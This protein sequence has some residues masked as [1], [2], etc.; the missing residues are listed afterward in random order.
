MSGYQPLVP[1]DGAPAMWSLSITTFRGCAPGARHFYARI[2]GPDRTVNVM[3]R[4]TESDLAHLNPENGD[5]IG[6]ETERF[7]TIDDA[8]AAGIAAFAVVSGRDDILV[9]EID[10][11]WPLVAPLD[12]LREAE[13]LRLRGLLTTWLQVLGRYR[14]WQPG[15]RR[16]GQEVI[17]QRSGN[18]WAVV[19]KGRVAF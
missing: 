12:V 6:M 8:T 10:E 3:Y 14:Q 18:G 7:P 5:R 1:A 9:P 13:A 17:V 4:I 2:E 11:E 16:G 15:V 19:E